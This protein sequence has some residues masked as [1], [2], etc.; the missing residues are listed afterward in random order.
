MKAL[1]TSFIFLHSSTGNHCDHQEEHRPQ[2]SRLGLTLRLL[3]LDS[4]ASVN[5]SSVVKTVCRWVRSSSFFS[6]HGEKERERGVHVKEAAGAVCAR[7]VCHISAC[8]RLMQMG[9]GL[10]GT[11]PWE[12]VGANPAC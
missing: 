6:C 1:L 3:T 7:F 9:R 4:I 2:T 8:L 5:R 12:T 10:G 11:A